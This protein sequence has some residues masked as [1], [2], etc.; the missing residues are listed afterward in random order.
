[1]L[2]HKVLGCL[3]DDPCI[4]GSSA[5]RNLSLKLC[6]LISNRDFS[7]EVVPYHT[8]PHMFAGASAS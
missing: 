3:V 8:L 2:E 5:A 7:T 1:M 6:E 4:F